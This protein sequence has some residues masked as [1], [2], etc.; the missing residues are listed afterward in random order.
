M[1]TECVLKSTQTKDSFVGDCKRNW[2]GSRGKTDAEMTKS[3]WTFLCLINLDKKS[4]HTLIS[5][6][7]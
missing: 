1:A 7:R 6:D 4:V 5:W 3:T 2:K